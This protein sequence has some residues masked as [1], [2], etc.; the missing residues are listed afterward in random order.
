MNRHSTS[1]CAIVF[2][3]VATLGS[4]SRPDALA[5]V[6]PNVQVSMARSTIPLFE[7]LAAADP[8]NPNRM[9]ACSAAYPTDES[10]GVTI[11]YASNDDGL[12]WSPTLA[13]KD[14]PRSGD[15][16]C[17]FGPDGAAYYATLSFSAEGKSAMHF[18]RSSDGGSTWS[19]P[20]RL[21]FIDREFITVDMS[22]GKYQ[23]RIYL[24]GTGLVSAIEGARRNTDFTLFRSS[25]GGATFQAPVKRSAFGAR[26]VR[27]MGN[28]V[29]LSDG[30]FLALF[31]EVK[32]YWNDEGTRGRV[33]PGPWGES[34]AWLRVIRSEDGGE[35]LDAGVT[36]ADWYT[37][38][39]GGAAVPSLA[40]DPGSRAFKNRVY[41]AWSDARSGRL[42]ILLAYSADR[43][44]TWSKPV[45]VNDDRPPADPNAGPDQLMPTVAVNRRGVVGVAWYDR[46]D[47]SP[48]S[49]GWWVR[50][51]PSLDGGETFLP[52]V[53]VSAAPNTY[54][55][56]EQRPLSGF[57]IGGAASDQRMRGGLIGLSIGMHWF[58]GTGGDTAGLAADAGGVFHPVWIDNRSGVP[59]MWTA[60][61]S[62]AGSVLKNGSAE[63]AELEDLT[64][65]VALEMIDFGFN[66]S[67]GQATARVRLKNGSKETLRGPFKLRVL[68]VRSYLAQVEVVGA[69]NGVSGAGA[70][71]DFTPLVAG[72]SLPPDAQ[73]DVKTLTFRLHDLRPPRTMTIERM[74][75]SLVSLDARVLGKS[76]GTS[77][78]EVR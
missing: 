2:F 72:G 73:S 39:K 75:E 58:S 27:S 1:L 23:G 71:F 33:Q 60:A 31:G 45:V 61:I 25:D 11:V 56:S 48:T 46:A 14:L 57:A 44:K 13:E 66:R 6:G 34:S 22:G 74:R 24:N 28:G 5:V 67:N 10:L 38:M 62:V 16:A 36:V 77:A 8:T 3:A 69:D 65:K 15:P 37:E 70:V 17:A 32:E 47:L 42:E 55:R 12:T 41:A 50:F 53:R 20:T 26:Y 29:V 64:S 30:T 68:A 7:T 54:G 76:M 78:T 35:T 9:L 63:L 59:Q 4:Q 21:P 40:A 18:Y 43:G 52:S 19:P 49:M 51:R